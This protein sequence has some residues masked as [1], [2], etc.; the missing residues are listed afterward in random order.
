MVLALAGRLVV[1][2]V[3]VSSFHRRCLRHGPLR[4]PKTMND[5]DNDVL[6]T[7]FFGKVSVDFKLLKQK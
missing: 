4:G 7:R 1:V 6:A 2:V 3:V 5:G